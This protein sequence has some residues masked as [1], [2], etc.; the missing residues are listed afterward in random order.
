M[1]P[2]SA[3]FSKRLSIYLLNLNICSIKFGWI[4]SKEKQ[5]E[6]RERESKQSPYCLLINYIFTEEK[7]S[8]HREGK[9]SEK[10]EPYLFILFKKK[11][12]PF[13]A[14]FSK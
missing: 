4:K 3:N 14:D 7:V 8:F 13:E 11:N 1:P 12:Q 9:K 2:T 6:N 10:F 5:L